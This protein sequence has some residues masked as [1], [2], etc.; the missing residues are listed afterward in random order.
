METE[1]SSRVP[2]IQIIESLYPKK[3]GL[4]NIDPKKFIDLLK[5]VGP[6]WL[7]FFTFNLASP[8]AKTIQGINRMF[9]R[10]EIK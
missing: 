10:T 4:N 8:T 6:D 3:V 1:L 7:D 2:F 5:D 9:A